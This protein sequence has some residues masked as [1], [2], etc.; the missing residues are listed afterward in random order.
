MRM[1]RNQA[2]R[3]PLQISALSRRQGLPGYGT[4]TASLFWSPA[5]PVRFK[6]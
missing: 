1:T 3:L 2:N 5:M 6:T 4:A